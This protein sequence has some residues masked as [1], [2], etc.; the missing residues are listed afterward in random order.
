MTDPAPTP[1]PEADL[2][3]IRRVME[4]AR[5]TASH[6]G[7]HL[8]LWGSLLA[9]AHALAYLARHGGM[10]VSVTLI[11]A[12]AVATGF[13]GSFLIG[14]RVWKRAPVDSLANRMLGAIWI[15]CALSMSLVGFLGAGSGSVPPDTLPGIQA[16]IIGTTFFASALLP[17][18]TMYW[19][20]A[21]A[22]WTI[23]G[24]LLVRPSP[25]AN[26]VAA[27]GLVLFMVAPGVW[28]RA[29]SGTPFRLHLVA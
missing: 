28:L 13:V 22:W 7:G 14:N 15:G 17:N 2:A 5:E 11:W 29:R 1:G 23:G 18:R 3:F 20:L 25:E 10:T 9:A 16:V 27:G 21:A 8:I 19:L 6:G 24:A 4:G 26:L 12:I